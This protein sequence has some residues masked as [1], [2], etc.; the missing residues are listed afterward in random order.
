[1]KKIMNYLATYKLMLVA[2]G[3]IL[4]G[5]AG[6][7]GS[8][9]N[10]PPADY[11]I[12]AIPGNEVQGNEFVIGGLSTYYYRQAM[13]ATSTNACSIR[14]PNA[15]TTFVGASMATQMTNLVGSTITRLFISTAT[16]NWASTTVLAANTIT[17]ARNGDLN[18]TSTNGTAQLTDNLVPPNTYVNFATIGTSTA[19][20]GL[21]GVCN[22]QLRQ[23]Q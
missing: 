8:Y 13:S 6:L 4:A 15:T 16:N 18:A 17:A 7:I 1:M 9:K 21:R 12:G 11:A 19:D 10:A 5:I 14:T 20:I 2:V 23:L 22:L 3:V